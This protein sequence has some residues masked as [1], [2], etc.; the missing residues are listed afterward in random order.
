[1]STYPLL[2]RMETSVALLSPLLNRVTFATIGALEDFS[3]R[4][5]CTEKLPKMTLLDVVNVA[6]SA[7]MD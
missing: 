3:S 5:S 2:V 1:M 6:A 7:A 4:D